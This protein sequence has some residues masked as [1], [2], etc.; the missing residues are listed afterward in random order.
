MTA[1][2]PER[3]ERL[4]KL[5]D[6]ELVRRCNEERPMA[7]LWGGPDEQGEEQRNI[8]GKGVRFEAFR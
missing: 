7:R 3:A 5:Y 2:S 8:G 1:L 4:R 6:E